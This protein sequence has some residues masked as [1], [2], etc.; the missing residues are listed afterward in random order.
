MLVLVIAVLAALGVV[1]TAAFLFRRLSRGTDDLAP[2]G[3]SAGHAG[4]MLSAMFLLVFAIAIVV[5]WTTADAA[6]LNTYGESQA[7]VETYWA[8][9]GL[10]APAATAVQSQVRGYL[11]FVVGKE[12]PLMASG[13]LSPEGTSRLNAMRTQMGNLVLQDDDA[14]NAR[15]AVLE[16]LQSMSSSRR[17]R[18]ADARSEPPAGV[19]PLAILTGTIVILFPF[20]A[21]ARPRGWT[22]VPLTVMSGLLGVGVFLAWQ[23]SHVFASGLSIG[24]DAFTVALLEIQQIPTSG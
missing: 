12:W 3:P 15:A 22:L 9:T 13:R 18:A 19:L 5:P 4:S 14:K 6:R 8:A 17:Q 20:L 2:N 7:A 1:G 24:P 23:I 21:G 16:Q 11:D 10:P